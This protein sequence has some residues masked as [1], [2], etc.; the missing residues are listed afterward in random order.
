MSLRQTDQGTEHGN[1]ETDPNV[2]GNS[3]YEEDG[4]FKSG[5]VW[6]GN[7]VFNKSFRDIGLFGK[8]TVGSV[9]FSPHTKVNSTKD[10]LKI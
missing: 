8:N 4:D 9:H 7:G 3:E 6:V 2:N 1:P 10:G 5:A